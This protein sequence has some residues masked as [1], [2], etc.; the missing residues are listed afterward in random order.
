[1][2]GS[3]EI[4]FLI[5][6]TAEGKRGL[7]I[8]ISQGK[9][10][11]SVLFNQ[12]ILVLSMSSQRDQIFRNVELLIY[13]FDVESRESEKDLVYFQNMIQGIHENSKDAT[14]YCLI[15]KMD[16]VEERQRER[17]LSNWKAELEKR[18]SP[19]HP[20]IFGTTIWDESLYKAWSSIV[21][22]LIPNVHLLESGLKKLC[23]LCEAS[24]VILFEKVWITSTNLTLFIIIDYFSCYIAY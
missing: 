14:I 3:W 5:Y 1:M 21:Y 16:L 15:H 18:C 2:F 11:G 13:V 23:T 4:W 7:W 20:I 8:I 9:Y 6:G 19:S 17:V 24:E 12:I 22:S 10:W